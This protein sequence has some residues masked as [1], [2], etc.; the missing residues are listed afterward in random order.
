MRMIFSQ[1]LDG[2]PNL[3][4]HRIDRRKS[5]IRKYPEKSVEVFSIATPKGRERG[6]TRH[7]FSR[8]R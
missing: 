2:D 5:E 1:I 8:Q 6:N 3:A 7:D 4:G